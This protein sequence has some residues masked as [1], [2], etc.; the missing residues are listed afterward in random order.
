VRRPVV[1][2]V[3]LAALAALARRASRSGQTEKDVWTEATTPPDLR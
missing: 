2:A 3:V 1:L